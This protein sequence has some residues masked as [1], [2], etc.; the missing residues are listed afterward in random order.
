MEPCCLGFGDDGVEVA[1]HFG[2][3]HGVDF[4]ARVVAF[5]DEL[6]EIAAGDLR[7]EMVGDYFAGALLLLDPGCAWAA[8]S[9]WGGRST[10]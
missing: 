5:F 2:H 7:G 9:T 4:A 6:L 3:G 8:R 10:S 1:E